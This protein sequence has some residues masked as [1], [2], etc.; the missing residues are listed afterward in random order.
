MAS[1]DNRHC[2]ICI[3]TLSFPIRHGAEA[4]KAAC[5]TMT[6]NY[7]YRQTERQT[8]FALLLGALQAPPP[9]PLARWTRLVSK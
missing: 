5:K 3:G 4:N 9:A 6:D 7:S 2:A 8:V 1:P